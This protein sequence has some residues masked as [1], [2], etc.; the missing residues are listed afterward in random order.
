MCPDP[1]RIPPNAATR[2]ADRSREAVAARDRAALEELC[3]PTMLFDDRRRMV[4][5]TGGRDMF[6]A[7]ARLIA[8]TR[9]SRSILATVGDRLALERLLWMGSYDGGGFESDNLEIIEVDGAGRIVTIIMFDPDDRRAASSELRERYARGDDPL[10]VSPV[11]IEFARAV[12]DHD[13]MAVRRVLSGDFV[14][15]DRRRVGA[16][17]IEGADGYLAYLAALFELSPDA[18][19]EALHFIGVEDHGYLAFAR[20]SGTLTEGGEFESLFVLFVHYPGGRPIA[21]ELFELEDLDVAR[22]RFEE[23]RTRSR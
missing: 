2:A 6:L 14:F 22:R 3:A 5:T 10:K 4:V 8:R 17:R 13:L 18:T 20:T 9:V 19:I 21:A 23:L 1:L 11:A 12:H 15:H 7:N 16:G